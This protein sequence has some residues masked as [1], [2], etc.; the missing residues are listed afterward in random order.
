MLLTLPGSCLSHQL[1]FPP[2]I[3]CSK[4]SQRLSDMECANFLCLSCRHEVDFAW[5]R[6]V[7]IYHPLPSLAGC[8]RQQ[9]EPETGRP[10]L[11]NLCVCCRH[12]ADFAWPVAVPKYHPFP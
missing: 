7:P 8:S 9:A 1:P 11:T 2:S 5:Q 4:Q 3:G 12:D 6:S 10:V